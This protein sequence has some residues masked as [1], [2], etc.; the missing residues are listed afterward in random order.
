MKSKIYVF[1]VIIIAISIAL[2]SCK[3]EKT[4]TPPE[5]P[6]VPL[7]N[8]NTMAGLG[9]VHG[10]PTGTVYHLPS[11]IH[12]IGSIR[13]GIQYKTYQIDKD[14]Y[15]GPFSS[16][17]SEKSWIN[18]GTGTYIHLYVKFYNSLAT[19]VTLS[20]PGGLIFCDSLDIV[21][22]LGIYQ[23][24]YILQALNIPIPAQD[25]AFA[26][27]KAYCLNHT[28]LP[29]SYNAV[30]YIGPVTNNP[31]LNLIKTIM[32]PKQPPIG[33]EYSIQTIIWKVTDYGLVLDTTDINYLNSL[34]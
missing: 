3:K 19:N 16:S 25:T 33:N 29:S 32:A 15:Q 21:D 27:I 1:L 28:L 6:S 11:N 23:K 22:S 20:I 2:P 18:Y 34:P 5:T 24:G 7:P 10:Y 8:E 4:Q 30:Y 14:K 12:I 17:I 26:C 13:G 31:Q 9:N